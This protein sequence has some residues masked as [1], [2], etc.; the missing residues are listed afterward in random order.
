MCGKAGTLF[1]T[2]I[3]LIGE[4]KRF[5]FCLRNTCKIDYF[6]KCFNQL[7]LNFDENDILMALVH[8]F[9]FKSGF[10]YIQKRCWRK[11]NIES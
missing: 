4:A 10:K 6:N 3:S 11:A 5:F 9:I 1:P 7:N 2:D 8:W